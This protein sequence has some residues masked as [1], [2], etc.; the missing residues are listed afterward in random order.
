MSKSRRSVVIEFVIVTLGV[1]LALAADSAV[2]RY[3]DQAAAQSALVAVRR[4]VGAD[5]EALGGRLDRLRNGFEARRRLTAV[6]VDEAEIQD[7]V[8]FV[9]DL[10]LLVDY[11]TFDASTAAVEGLRSSGRFDLIANAELREA[12][13]EYLNAVEN[14]AEADVAR[15]QAILIYSERLLPRLFEGTEWK[16]RLGRSE[17]ERRA[18]ASGALNGTVIRESGALRELL[19]LTESPLGW[20]GFLYRQTLEEAET[21]AR[22]LDEEIGA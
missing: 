2:E 1:A 11:L 6:A 7:S 3:R 13:L 18:W 21:L 8:L 10:S 4:D 12:L 5:I 17:L 19:L 14:V 9:D 15:R 20:Q 22:L 16:G